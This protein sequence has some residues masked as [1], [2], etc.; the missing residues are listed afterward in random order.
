VLTGLYP[1]IEII[2]E[3]GT[4]QPVSEW[5]ELDQALTKHVWRDL[6]CY[7]PL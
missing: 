5:A 6:L 7:S 3:G 2:G 4:L 1:R